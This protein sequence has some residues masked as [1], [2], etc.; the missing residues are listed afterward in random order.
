MVIG[1]RRNI[2]VYIVSPF[3][4]LSRIKNK[5]E[6]EMYRVLSLSLFGKSVFCFGFPLFIVV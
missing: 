2:N 3:L 6:K 5:T 4:S 1:P